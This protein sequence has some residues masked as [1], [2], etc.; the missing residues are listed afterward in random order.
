M[1][2]LPATPEDDFTRDQILVYDI[3]YSEQP[4]AI[5]NRLMTSHQDM[6]IKR[7]WDAV[8]DQPLGGTALSNQVRRRVRSKNDM[9]SFSVNVKPCKFFHN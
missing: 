2:V 7:V 9:T 3:L 1:K 4:K 8:D 5:L 6:T